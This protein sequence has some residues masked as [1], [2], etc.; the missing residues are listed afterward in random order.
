MVSYKTPCL[1]SVTRRQMPTRRK[2]PAFAPYAYWWPTITLLCAGGLCDLL[3]ESPKFTVVAEAEEGHE[4]LAKGRE[5]RPD[6]VLLD[7]NM[8]GLSAVELIREL[9]T[10]PNPPRVLVVSGYAE[11]ECVTQALRAGADGYLLKTERLAVLAKAV[12]AVCRGETWLSRR[13]E[14]HPAPGAPGQIRIGGLVVDLQRRVVTL[15]GN[16]VPLSPIEYSVLAYLAQRAGK[17]VSAEELLRAIWGKDLAHGGTTAQVRNCIY[18][19]RKKLAPLSV[20]TDYIKT[21]R[22]WGHALEAPPLEG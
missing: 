17:P 5:L 3:E 4:T 11:A 2:K 16:V 18:R 20:P 7:F 13:L 19:L 21:R 9:K 15:R 10:L 8:P 6:V 1:R 12:Q 22:G 14:V